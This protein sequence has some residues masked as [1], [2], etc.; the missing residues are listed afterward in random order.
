MFIATRNAFQRFTYLVSYISS[1][2][3]RAYLLSYFMTKGIKRRKVNE[4]KSCLG[5]F[6]G[7]A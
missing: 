2:E 5:A 4:L 1:R 6:V 3:L 7:G